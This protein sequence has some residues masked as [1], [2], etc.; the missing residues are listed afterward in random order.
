MGGAKFKSLPCLITSDLCLLTK[1]KSARDFIVWWKSKQSVDKWVKLKPGPC[2]PAWN[3]RT[4]LHHCS[5]RSGDNY[6]ADGCVKQQRPSRV[7]A[8]SRHRQWR[9]FCYSLTCDFSAVFGGKTADQTERSRPCVYLSCQSSLLS[10]SSESSETCSWPRSVT[11]LLLLFWVWGAVES[12]V[13]CSALQKYQSSKKRKDLFIARK[14]FRNQ[15]Y[16]R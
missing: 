15:R 6:Q 5:Y 12:E 13:S 16:K 10:L 14:G 4:H 1:K 8:S 11:C 3:T 2:W 9:L 7:Q